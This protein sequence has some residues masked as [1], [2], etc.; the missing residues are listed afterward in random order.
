MPI[1]SLSAPDASV[2]PPT[3]W[4]RNPHLGWALAVFVLTVVLTCI[5]FPP[6]EAS[7]F[8]FAFALPAVL[9]A[10]RA[11]PFKIYAWTLLAAQAVAWTILLGWLHHVTWGGLFLLGPF[12]GMLIGLW[13]LAVR[14]TMPR[15]R[16]HQ[17]FVRSLAL[18]GL[19]GL[20]VMLEWVRGI[21]FGGFP[22]LPLAASQWQR[23]FM[24]QM[25]AYAGA[26]AISFVLVVFNLGI[27]AYA[28]RIFFE[29]ATGLR[30]RSPEFT[31]TLLVLIAATFPFIGDALNQQ[32]RQLMRVA[33]IQPYI[34][35]GEKWDG[36]KAKEILRTI[37]KVTLDANEASA[38][39][40]IFWPEASVPWVLQRDPSMN[41]WVE[42]MA[43]RTGK[44]L[45]IGAVAVDEPG[46]P[47]EVWRNGAFVIDPKWGVQLPG[48]SKRHLVPFGEFIPLRSVFGWL[49]KFVPIGG[50]FAP[51]ETA[52]PLPVKVGPKTVSVG[53]LICYE[54]LFPALARSSTRAGA[55]V[56][57]VLTNDAWYGEGGAATQHAAHS[58]LR[59]VEN[60]RPVV[61]C[62]NGGWSGWIDEFGN[63]RATAIDEDGSIY[64][65]GHKTVTVTR[66]ARWQGR[67]S[68]YVENGDWFVLLSA[69][70]ATLAYVVVLVLRPPPIRPDGETVF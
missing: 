25:A 58:V 63:I 3:L 60:R 66:D 29:G 42:S 57:A 61:R 26:W 4:Q 23:T 44:P 40:V 35:Q 9:W 55:E 16:G 67:L 54:D 56:L 24:L 37:E 46:V 52:Q 12:I 21:I 51:G 5:S 39:D 7:E 30:K 17:M 49:E 68:A 59:A 19:A 41:E 50:D 14:W 70:L 47:A 69:A 15:L 34:P 28:H 53:V 13:Y 20:W 43:R 48:Y 11:P 45:L 10:Y 65:R 36:A 6:M 22:W 31:I 18:L 64:F 33:L 38:A 32:R 2:P 1:Q 8:A 62:G 27:A